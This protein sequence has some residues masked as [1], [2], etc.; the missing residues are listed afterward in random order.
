MSA[1]RGALHSPRPDDCEIS[2]SA[3]KFTSLTRDEQLP[4]LDSREN[5]ARLAAARRPKNGWLPTNE[6]NAIHKFE[7]KRS[8]GETC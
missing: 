2:S 6:G 1:L 4:L 8:R 5:S 3:F 7:V